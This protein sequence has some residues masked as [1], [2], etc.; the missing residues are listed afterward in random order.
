V[1]GL[2]KK[3]EGIEKRISELDKDFK[4]LDALVKSKLEGPKC[5]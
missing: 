1:Q 5:Q 2:K 4:K 3:E